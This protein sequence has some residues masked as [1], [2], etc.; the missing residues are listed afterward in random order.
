MTGQILI[1]PKTARQ[2]LEC[3]HRSTMIPPPSPHN[4]TNLECSASCTVLGPTG[5][6]QG[7]YS[8]YHLGT[9]RVIKSNY[10]TVIPIPHEVIACVEETATYQNLPNDLIFS[11]ATGDVTD[12][13]TLDKHQL[14][15]PLSMRCM[16]HRSAREGGPFMGVHPTLEHTPDQVPAPGP[17]YN[18]PVH[19]TPIFPPVLDNGV[20]YL[21]EGNDKVS[22]AR[23]RM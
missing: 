9:G 12:G 19:Q 14:T 22:S 18:P 2:N 20:E 8:F 15:D 1:S 7:T 23:G 4:S 10:F 17:A 16:G 3:I 5:N 6:V 13:E 21:G 11:L